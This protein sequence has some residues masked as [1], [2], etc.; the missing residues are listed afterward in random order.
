MKS[1]GTRVEDRVAVLLTRC[2]VACSAEIGS[3]AAGKILDL[4]LILLRLSRY[5]SDFDATLPGLFVVGI[6]AGHVCNR[7]GGIL[8]I[9]NQSIS[10]AQSYL[11]ARE[12][13]KVLAASY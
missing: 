8:D 13:A 11:A 5:S 6:T 10:L 1:S 2:I 4:V 9:E 12:K 7:V 3:E